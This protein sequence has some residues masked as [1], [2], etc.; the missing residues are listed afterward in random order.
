MADD[1]KTSDVGEE[2]KGGALLQ[3]F[4]DLID[5]GD[6]QRHM[7]LNALVR[8]T[9]WKTGVAFP[10]Y[11]SLAEI[12]KCSRKT[13]QRHLHKMEEDHLLYIEKRFDFDGSG[14]QTSNLI[15]FVGYADW[16]KALREG[17]TVKR[18]RTTAKRRGPRGQ[19]DQGA[20]GQD[21]QG[22]R[23]QDDQG[24]PVDN[25]S[26]GH[27]LQETSPPGQQVS[28]LDPSL[29]PSLGPETPPQV[30]RRRGTR[31][32]FDLI[33]EVTARRPE[34]QRAIDALLRPVLAR[35]KFDA[36][37]P[38]FALSRIA[39][40]GEK[41]SDEVLAEALRMLTEPGKH[42]RRHS[43][44]PADIEDAVRDAR[45]LVK[46]RAAAQA[47]V[48]EVFVTGTPEF[49][50]MIAKVEKFNPTEAGWLR[51]RNCVKRKEV[52]K[53]LDRDDENTVDGAAA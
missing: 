53:Y 32:K 17:G 38:V 51:S 26:R 21:D 22:G 35:I 2:A 11:K 30:P 42:Y 39:E 12:A 48:S 46:E 15:T 33:S 8:F 19:S 37:E 47:R 49:A 16:L 44:K 20:H 24:L 18:P 7:V 34:C 3:A 27:G 13:V 9:D 14:R 5:T 52:A 45:S 36:P 28:S 29:D 23:G 10:N 4:V 43:A 6:A 40:W 41:Q 31:E 50:D 1:K 25:V